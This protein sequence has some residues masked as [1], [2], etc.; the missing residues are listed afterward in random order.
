MIGDD[1]LCRSSLYIVTQDI[2]I[3]ISNTWPSAHDLIKVIDSDLLAFERFDERFAWGRCHIRFIISCD[4]F[5]DN[6][7]VYVG[8]SSL[9]L[10]QGPSMNAGMGSARQLVFSSL[11]GGLEGGWDVMIRSF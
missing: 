3:G 6:G 10:T 1:I 5:L 8:K 7:Q 2:E 4:F 11:D 9:L